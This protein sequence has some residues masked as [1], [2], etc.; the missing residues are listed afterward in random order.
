M[1]QS[2]YHQVNSVVFTIW[3]AYTHT[4]LVITA[5]CFYLLHT[6]AAG[7][8]SSTPTSCPMFWFHINH[9]FLPCALCICHIPVIHVCWILLCYLLHF[10]AAWMLRGAFLSPSHTNMKPFVAINGPVAL[11]RKCF[12]IIHSYCKL[13][14]DTAKYKNKISWQYENIVCCLD[15]K[16]MYRKGG[17]NPAIATKQIN[18]SKRFHQTMKEKC[19]AH[20]CTHVLVLESLSLPL[21]MPIISNKDGCSFHF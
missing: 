3:Q 21:E 5:V 17:V 11:W 10:S 13:T 12:W 14:A 19:C 20:R 2:H 7:Y 18:I 8:T 6:A 9:T 4:L 15:K 1:L 16:T